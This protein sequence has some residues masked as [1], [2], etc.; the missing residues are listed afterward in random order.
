MIAP[1][2]KHG[3]GWGSDHYPPYIDPNPDINRKLPTGRKSYFLQLCPGWGQHCTRA[4][5][6]IHVRDLLKMSNVRSEPLSITARTI[7]RHEEQR[8][9]LCFENRRVGVF[10]C[11]HEKSHFPARKKKSFLSLC[12]C[13]WMRIKA[14]RPEGLRSARVQGFTV[15]ASYDSHHI[16][17]S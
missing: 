10:S 11:Y 16:C 15:L 9:A 14:S 4:T 7:A 5:L 12:V 17:K 8:L 3:S 6:S 1:P 13:S 2:V